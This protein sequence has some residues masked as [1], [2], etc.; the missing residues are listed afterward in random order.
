MN[1]NVVFDVPAKV[2]QGLLNGS[3]ERV[4]GVVRDTSSKQVVMWLQEGGST[5]SQAIAQ[6]PLAGGA[7]A[8]GG[9]S[10]VLNAAN[11]AVTAAGFAVVIQQLNRISDQI[12]SIEAKIDRV[13]DKL[14]DLALA[15][16][17]AGIN[18][19]QDAVDHTDPAIRVTMAGHAIT[20]LH[21]ARQY[22]NQQAIRSAGKAEAASAHY[23]AL[24]FVALAAE[25]QTYVE[26]DNSPKAARVIRQGLEDLRPGLT[27]LMNAVLDCS[28]HYL[29]PDF[30][31]VVE[32]DLI[33]WLHNGM[34]R[35]Q[36]GPHQPVDAISASDLF[37][38]MRPRIT[39]VFKNYEDWHGQIPQVVVDTSTVPD[40]WWGPLPQGVDKT[41]RFKMV[42]QELP[43]GLNKMV[44]LVESYDRLTGQVLQL[45]EM[46]RLE[47]KPSQLQQLRSL[48][49]GQAAA[50]VLDPRWMTAEVTA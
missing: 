28:C 21:E 50:L 38:W 11:L 42:K 34:K 18:A 24:A 8:I 4:G 3:L 43:A 49:Q 25:A 33:L 36:R 19:C 37:E 14:D 30:A 12:K 44:A 6:P 16:L 23:V 29:K 1:I 45:E 35:I 47:L 9:A 2:A 27:Q 13:S 22:F 20:A 39:D 48:P 31:G 7:G 15:K 41:A 5:V 17:K 32:L 40:W 46:A 10:L 26:L